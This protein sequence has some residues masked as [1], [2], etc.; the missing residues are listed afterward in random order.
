[1]SNRN[2]LGFT[3][4]ELL[5]VIAIIAVL[6]ALLLPAVQ[7]ARE[8][9]RRAQCI[10]NLKQ[11]GLAVANYE[12]A[13]GALPP[14]AICNT[15]SNTADPCFVSYPIISMKGRLLPFL[16]QTPLYNAFNMLG[17]DYNSPANWTVRTTQ[18]NTL[19]CPSD[20]NLPGM[21]ATLSGV[22][23][24]IGYSNYPNN[25][26]TYFRNTG[27]LFDGPAYS[28]GVPSSGGTVTLATVTDG[29]SNTVMFSEWIKG[30]GQLTADPLNTI[31]QDT[32][33]ADASGKPIP[34]LTL[35]QDCLRSTKPF[36]E[37][38]GTLRGAQKGGEWLEHNCNAGGCY[39][40]TQTP[41]KKGC[42]FS[43]DTA[44]HSDHTVVGASSFHPGGVNVAMI[45]GSVRFVKSTVSTQ[46]WWAI[47]TKSGGEVVSADSF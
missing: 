37:P 12:S 41:N 38:N 30:T 43:N 9:A 5:V 44:F 17:N 21:T 24:P 36:V 25:I 20:G 31:Y 15:R 26:G 7:A 29:T 27:N 13:N 1:M 6:I 35:G 40:H 45:D 33:D 18:V 10:N 4:I 34:L 28:M 14:T 22:T 47:A 11:L 2:R 39:S 23:R 46:T 42:V 3:L 8:A 16:E 19:V 32:V